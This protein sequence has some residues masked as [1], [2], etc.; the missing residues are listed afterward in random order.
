MRREWMGRG[1]GIRFGDPAS[2]VLLDGTPVAGHRSL[3]GGV[4]IE[5]VHDLVGRSVVAQRRHATSMA[6]L[7]LRGDLTANGVPVRDSRLLCIPVLVDA[8]GEASSPEDRLFVDVVRVALTRALAGAEPLAVHAYAP[9]MDSFAPGRDFAAWIRLTPRETLTGSRQRLGRIT[10][11]GRRDPRQ[12]LVLGATAV[13]R[14]ARR[15]KEITDPLL[16]RMLAEKPP[17]L[18]A[19]AMAN[20]M[21]RIIWAMAPE[22]AT[23]HRRCSVRSRDRDGPGRN[24]EH[25]AFRHASANT[26]T[27]CGQDGER[28][29]GKR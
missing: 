27:G 6:S 23:A 7:I 11:K 3:D 21:A 4:V 25:G 20:K 13:I 15:R 24:H 5:D 19:V 26:P 28:S 16:R 12:L 18:V 14:H 2:A 1:S 9:D 10:K 8:E 22:R 29:R 17:K